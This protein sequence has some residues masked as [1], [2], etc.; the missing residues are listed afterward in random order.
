MSRRSKGESSSQSPEG[1]AYVFDVVRVFFRAQDLVDF[2]AEAL[3]YTQRQTCVLVKRII[4]F[5]SDL[6]M[7]CGD[8]SAFCTPHNIMAWCC[9]HGL[10][11]S[12]Q[13]RRTADA[14][15]DMRRD[16]QNMKSGYGCRAEQRGV[17]CHGFSCARSRRALHVA[18]FGIITAP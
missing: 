4:P 16:N 18:I 1:L 7:V 8:S 12:G 11:S 17:G 9:G 13:G 2:H 10:Y 6:N 14:P 5:D 3:P 15:C